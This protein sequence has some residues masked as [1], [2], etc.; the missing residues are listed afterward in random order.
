MKIEFLLMALLKRP[1]GLS[2]NFTLDIKEGTKL[3]TILLDLGYTNQEIRMF[4]LFVAKD[5]NEDSERI[6]RSYE[7]TDG[8]K[9]M[10]TIPVGG[11]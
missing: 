2:R 7:P 9:I 1:K 11:G 3:K 5:G 6:S 10:V 4:Q 8:D